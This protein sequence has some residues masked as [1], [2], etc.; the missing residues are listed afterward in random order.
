MK[1]VDGSLLESLHYNDVI[2]NTIASQITSP[3][4]VY[5]RR[6]SKKTSKIRVTGLYEGNSPVTGGFPAQRTSNA[7]NVSMSW[8]H[9]G[10]RRNREQACFAGAQ[11]VFLYIYKLHSCSSWGIELC[12]PEPHPRSYSCGD[13]SRLDLRLTIRLHNQMILQKM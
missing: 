8:R 5:S 4:I 9:H 7:E 10:N 2:M 1:L 6:R 13:P 3:T 12:I 11:T